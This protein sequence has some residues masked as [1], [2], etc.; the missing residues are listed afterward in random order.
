MV[1]PDGTYDNGS[2]IDETVATASQGR[3][4]TQAQSAGYTLFAALTN[5]GSISDSYTALRALLTVREL[6]EAI[7]T[8][9]ATCG[10]SLRTLNT[11]TQTLV[12]NTYQM[13]PT[14]GA[15]GFW[16]GM[17]VKAEVQFYV[18]QPTRDYI[19]LEGWR[20]LDDEIIQL[21][22]S[23]VDSFA[24]NLIR[25]TGYGPVYDNLSTD[26]PGTV[27]GTFDD[28][29]QIE[30]LTAA[31]KAAAFGTIAAKGPPSDSGRYRQ[32]QADA[33]AQFKDMQRKWSRGIPIQRT[34]RTPMGSISV[35]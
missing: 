33:L 24:G 17:V 30:M 1:D 16:P 35:Y 21:P 34:T 27:I 18:G 26:N 19:P 28:S 5:G 13:T 9:I 25:W 29:G 12:A 22:A 6:R 4:S 7:N 32:L 15:G 20:Y 8:G 3:I 2:I 14:Y 10:R 11:A 23:V 31:V